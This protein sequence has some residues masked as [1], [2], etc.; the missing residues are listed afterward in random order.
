MEEEKTRTKFRGRVTKLVNDLREYRQSKDIDQDD[1]AY[2]IHFFGKTTER[3][4]GHSK[5]LRQGRSTR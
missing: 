2:K 3:L 5:H 4:E 1:L